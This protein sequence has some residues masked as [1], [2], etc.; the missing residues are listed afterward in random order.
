M[1]CWPNWGYPT[2]SVSHIVSSA[3]GEGMVRD[4]LIYTLHHFHER[5]RIQLIEKD[6]AIPYIRSLA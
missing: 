2:S 5:G 3:V 6:G 4:W 1:D